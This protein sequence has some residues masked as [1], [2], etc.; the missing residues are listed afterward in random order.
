MVEARGAHKAF[1]GV[2]PENVVFGETLGEGKK[3][4]HYELPSRPFKLWTD[5][6]YCG[7]VL[8]VHSVW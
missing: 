1:D 3:R 5:V 8:Q 2:K 6:K 7:L 4:I